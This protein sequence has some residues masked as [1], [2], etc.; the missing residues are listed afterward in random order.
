MIHSYIQTS[1]FVWFNMIPN[2]F[3]QGPR[4]LLGPRGP[5]GPSG[6]PVSVSQ[7][8]F[9]NLMFM[10]FFFNL[11]PLIFAGN[12]WCWW[13]TWPQRK[14]GKR[15]SQPK[16]FVCCIII[17]FMPKRTH[18]NYCMSTHTSATTLSVIFICLWCIGTAGRTWSPG[19]TG[20]PRNT[21]KYKHQKKTFR[22]N[23]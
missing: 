1:I 13:S 23:M 14:H 7:Y 5:P 22:R 16:H 19:T 20:N 10:A 3:S 18:F 15:A 8:N 6:Q 11:W 21:S 12:R 17:A 2:L 4:G 9:V